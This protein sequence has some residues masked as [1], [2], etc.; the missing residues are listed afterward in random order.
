VLNLQV[1]QRG[2]FG[3]ALTLF[4]MTPG[5]VRS[6]EATSLDAPL[7]LAAAAL[8]EGRW[9]DAVSILRGSREPDDDEG[10]AAYLFALGLAEL[11]A[12]NPRGAVELLQE[13]LERR[14]DL[15]GARVALGRAYAAIGDAERS[16]MQLRRALAGTADDS[17]RRVVEDD[18]ARL[19]AD[20]RLTGSLSFAVV[21]DSNMGARTAASTIL[22]DGI[23]F[24]LDNAA[25][26]RSGVG[27]LT[28][29]G[30]S[31]YAPISNGVRLSAG[32]GIYYM[33]YENNQY[34]DLIGRVRIG[35]EFALGRGSL[36]VGPVA[37]RRWL[38]GKEFST[39]T[40]LG[41][42]LYQP[43]GQRAL[44]GSNIEIL[45]NI[46]DYHSWMN[47]TSWRLDVVSV[48]IIS[49][50]L[51]FRFGAGAG[52]ESARFE[53]YSNQQYR[54]SS[55]FLFDLN[56]GFGA[57]ISHEIMWR[58]FEGINFYETKA[59]SDTRH[60]NRF[61]ISNRRIEYAGFRPALAIVNER[62]RSSSV[63]FEYERFR[64]E[65]LFTRDF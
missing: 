36:A 46:H 55:A 50:N 58:E 7:S 51:R 34:D 5:T 29:G 11:G 3:V 45:S 27:L 6:A 59:R 37:Y 42:E 14:P 54:I 56:M 38:G 64:V 21:P 32:L 53:E 63:L 25:R 40:G 12:G 18:L 47:N 60:T 31:A 26:P 52:R 48:F 15:N 62:Q 2:L 39:S 22:I 57:L 16:D 24:K 8:A 35:P 33:N 17:R 13:T 43:L 10:A 1:L 30:A 61:E 23:P 20:R 4:I 9:S 44:L 49:S 41:L 28:T 65:I 19:R